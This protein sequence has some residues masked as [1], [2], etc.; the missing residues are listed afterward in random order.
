MAFADDYRRAMAEVDR[1]AAEEYRRVKALTDPLLGRAAQDPRARAAIAEIL[2]DV[3]PGLLSEYRLMSAEV[4]AAA[5]QAD[6][7]RAA[8]PGRSFA[9]VVPD[10]KDGGAHALV[11]WALSVA[12]SPTSL[13]ALILGG[14]Q[15]RGRDGGRLT[16]QSS[17]LADP[18][19][20]GWQRVDAGGDGSCAFCRM[21]IGRGAVY[22]EA[23][24][25]FG[26]H[27][28]CNC[29][30]APIW[31]G[32][33]PVPVPKWARSERADRAYNPQAPDSDE[34]RKASNERV[35]DWL[36]ANPDVG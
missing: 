23:S 21:L 19:A 11:G 16:V 14:Y 20:R 22:T 17:S 10:L 6:R 30:A 35:R 29:A 18:G 4:A 34:Q 1:I 8:V 28:N 31:K 26:A 15:R 9:P 27:D 12:E 24:V 13:D 36:A 32:A 2:H 33:A 25:R 3:L 5:Y 7:I